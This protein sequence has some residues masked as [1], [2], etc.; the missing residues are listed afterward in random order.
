MI[1]REK[2]T[3]VYIN[4]IRIEKTG[5]HKL[6]ITGILYMELSFPSLLFIMTEG[7]R[8]TDYK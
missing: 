6:E 3:D 5:F 8:N 7:Q 1:E 4:L 2:Y